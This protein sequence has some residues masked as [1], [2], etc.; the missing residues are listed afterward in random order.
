MLVMVTIFLLTVFHLIHVSSLTSE[1]ESTAKIWTYYPCSFILSSPTFYCQQT[2]VSSSIDQCINKEI[3]FFWHFPSG[4]MTIKLKSYDN[5]SFVLN[6]F[7]T[8]LLKKKLIKNIYHIVNDT[9][10]E[11]QL[12]NNYD[13][14][15][16]TIPSN[17]YNECS[18]KLETSN[19]IIFD[20]GTL[21]RM[22]IWTNGNNIH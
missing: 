18:I 22:V 16:I 20:Y 11:E 9:T 10:M 19:R 7:K 6:L 3:T 4:N 8:S 1:C 21:I 12:L 2:S 13:N 17:E 14:P 15:I 5:Q